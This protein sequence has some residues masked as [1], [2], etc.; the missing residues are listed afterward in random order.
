[1]RAGNYGWPLMEG[2]DCFLPSSCDTLGKNLR[3]PIT[4]Y[5][6]GVGNAVIS[7][8]VYRGTRLPELQGQYVFGDFSGG[9]WT[10]YYDGVNPPIVSDLVTSTSNILAMGVGNPPK[11]DVYLSLIDGSIQRLARVVP[12]GADTPAVAGSRLLGNFPNPFNPSTTIR[13]R[14]ERAARVRVEI[15]TVDGTL[16]RRLDDGRREAGVHA[17]GWHGETDAGSRTA[18]GV[19]FYRLVVDGTVADTARMVLLQ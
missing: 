7:G 6:H 9:L 5:D 1:E 15:V 12:T 8:Y 11:N 14:L 4:Y 13:Y 3:A 17:L 2:P 10:I 16:V 18:S 19:Y